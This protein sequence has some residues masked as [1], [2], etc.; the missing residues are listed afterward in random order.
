MKL[1]KKIKE[2]KAPKGTWAL[3]TWSDVASKNCTKRPME[4]IYMNGDTEIGRELFDETIIDEIKDSM[5]IVIR[6]VHPCSASITSYTL[7]GSISFSRKI[8]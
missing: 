7:F 2:R 6:K 8:R 4:I 5:P 3:I 1:F